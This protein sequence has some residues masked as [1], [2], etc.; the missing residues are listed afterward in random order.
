MVKYERTESFEAPTILS[1]PGPFDEN[2]DIGPTDEEDS[3][4]WNA[5]PERDID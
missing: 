4:Y 2:T 3:D 1:D 5:D